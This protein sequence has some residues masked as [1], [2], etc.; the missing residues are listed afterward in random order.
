MSQFEGEREWSTYL[1][2]LC[3]HRPSAGLFPIIVSQDC[4]HKPTADAI[5]SYG[6]RVIHIK[7]G[8]LAHAYPY[9]EGVK[10]W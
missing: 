7:V 9:R 4:G 3:R 2:S 5:A 10:V 6:A 1:A 8:I